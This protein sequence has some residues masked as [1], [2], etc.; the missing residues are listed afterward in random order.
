MRFFMP[1]RPPTVTHQAKQLHAYMKG[2]KP[3]AVLHDTPELK[4]ARAQLHAALAP[5]APD[6]P[7]L[8]AVQLVVKWIFPAEGRPNGSWK[9]TKPD[10]DNLEKAL[11]DEMTRLHFWRDDA[12]VCSEI[13]EKFWG[14]TPGV[15][16]EVRAL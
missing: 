14:D 9:T 2:G 7:E 12:Q 10:T 6:A 11:K 5:H 4:D 3:S 8:G 15:Y 16:V 1:M 13:A